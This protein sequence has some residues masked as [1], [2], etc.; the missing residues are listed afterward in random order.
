MGLLF[1]IYQIKYIFNFHTPYPLPVDTI[2]LVQYFHPDFECL[3]LVGVYQ[4]PY[5]FISYAISLSTS[6]I[7]LTAKIKKEKKRKTTDEFKQ[8]SFGF[9]F[10]SEILLMIII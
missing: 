2:G 9:N 7:I 6:S 4:L 10:H 1:I 3:L 8:S 5:D